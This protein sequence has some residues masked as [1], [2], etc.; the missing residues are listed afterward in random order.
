MQKFDGSFFGTSPNGEQCKFEKVGS[1]NGPAILP[2][3]NSLATLSETIL[4]VL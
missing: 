2:A 3:S 4:N 1:N